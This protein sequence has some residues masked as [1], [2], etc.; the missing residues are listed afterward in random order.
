M[1]VTEKGPREGTGAKAELRGAWTTDVRGTGL[2]DEAG[3]RRPD[4][5]GC[6]C[7]HSQLSGSGVCCPKRELPDRLGGEAAWTT[8]RTEAEGA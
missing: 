8:D 2:K 4:G 3:Q 6:A 7:G 5:S 1:L